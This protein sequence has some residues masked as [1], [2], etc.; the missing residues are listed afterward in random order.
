[1]RIDFAQVPAL[2]FSKTA[3]S[4]IGCRIR[5][6]NKS[7]HRNTIENGVALHDCLRHRASTAPDNVASRYHISEHVR[8]SNS[9]LKN[10]EPLIACL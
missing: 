9:S 7:K 2:T 6:T 3:F 4:A 5:E 1:M 8:H 10:S